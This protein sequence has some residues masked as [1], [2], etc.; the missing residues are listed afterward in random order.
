METRARHLVAGIFVLALL[1]TLAG[2]VVWLGS[3][4]FSAGSRKYLIYFSRSVTG[5]QAGSPVR[6]QG[7]DV[8]KVIAI[9][10][11]S[12]DTTRVR[13]EVEMPARIPVRENSVASLEFQG[14]TGSVYIQIAPGLNGSPL[15]QP[16]AEGKL[17]VIPSRMQGGETVMAAAPE[18]LEN[19]TLL[20]QDVRT[21]FTPENM[22]NARQILENMQK[23]SGNMA[24]ATARLDGLTTQAEKA[25]ETMQKSAG[26]ITAGVTDMTASLRKSS[27]QLSRVLAENRDPIHTFTSTGLYEATLLMTEMRDLVARLSRIAARIERDPAKALFGPQDQGVKVK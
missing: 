26:D 5:L 27:D 13:V 21:L 15:L 17:P 22:E 4:Q 8:G 16:A 2:F 11:D 7:V 24:T 18:M 25:L 3:V 23:V 6:Y 20:T 9:D 10:I 14:I 19:L 12:E 1:A